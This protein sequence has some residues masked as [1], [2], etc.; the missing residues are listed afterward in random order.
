MKKSF[1]LSV[2]LF[3]F[4]LITLAQNPGYEKQYAVNSS[5]FFSGVLNLNSGPYQFAVKTYG[6][7]TNKRFAVGLNLN[8]GLNNSNFLGNLTGRARFGK[9]RFNDFGQNKQ[10]R[11][12]YGLDVVVLSGINTNGS[13]TSVALGVGPSPFAGIQYRLNKRL[14]L[15]VETSYDLI[16]QGAFASNTSAFN[17]RGQFTAPAALWIAYDMTPRKKEKG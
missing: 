11:V 9:E 10:W 16:L 12:V 3:G 2:C 5:A 13:A 14:S 17:L 7:Q 15:Y 6:E 1:L 4:S 8:A